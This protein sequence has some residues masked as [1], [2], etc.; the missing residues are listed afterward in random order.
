MIRVTNEMRSDDRL[1]DLT[2]D[3]DLTMSEHMSDDYGLDPDQKKADL[4]V[5]KVIGDPSKIYIVTSDSYGGE[6]VD[7]I[8]VW[9]SIDDA[10]S[11]SVGNYKLSKVGS[12]YA[13]VA[14]EGGLYILLITQS[15]AEY[16]NRL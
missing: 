7:F 10:S 9:T 5:A 6:L 2:R 16:L 15:S 3:A 12:D 14:Y 11:K 8:D 1:I 13:A 4:T